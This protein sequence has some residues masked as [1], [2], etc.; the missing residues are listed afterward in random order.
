MKTVALCSARG[1][2]GVTTTSLLLASHLDA[3]LV[4]AD[5]A[6]GVVAVRYG[7]SRE[8]GL[9]TL[10]AASPAGP[11][12]WRDHA[13]DAGGVPVL[14]GPD[15]ADTAESLWRTAGERIVAALDRS[16]GWAVVDAGRVWRRTWIVDA[17]DVV[18][19][20]ARPN[21]EELVAATHAAAALNAPGTKAPGGR[22]GVVLVG[23]GPYRAGDIDDSL[24]A[25]VLAHL[26]ADD[27]T[28]KHLRDGGTSGRAL[29]RSRLSRSVAGIVE[30][31]AHSDAPVAEMVVAR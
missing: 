10:A 23:E 14:V 4:E 20:L 25:P 24:G 1:A 17:A 29:A 12:G 19:V 11:G 16:E 9:V 18:L 28:A 8:P 30:L 7:L 2:P 5:L 26:P 15:A 13:Q 27:G 21:A 3:V 31:L 6:G 22:V